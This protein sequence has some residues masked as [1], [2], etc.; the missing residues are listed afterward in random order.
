MTREAALHVLVFVV[1]LALGLGLSAQRTPE[2]FAKSL[3]L[4]P[5]AEA[6]VVTDWLPGGWRV[7][8]EK[9]GAELR[10]C[11]TVRELR[12]QASREREA[13]AAAKDED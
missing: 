10:G 3:W 9:A 7:C 6:W 13:K 4:Y 12:G 11:V 1:F 2:S 8:A 5:E